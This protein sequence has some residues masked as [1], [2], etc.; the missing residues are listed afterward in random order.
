MWVE[1]LN[2]IGDV[3]DLLQIVH[4]FGLKLSMSLITLVA[5][6]FLHLK[7][8]DRY[9]DH[10]PVDDIQSSHLVLTVKLVCFY[11]VEF[12]NV[13]GVSLSLDN[14]QPV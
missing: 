9:V 14:L 7:D 1:L 2:P 11:L 12:F 5:E 6:A 10:L 3:D 13:F 4:P 8:Q